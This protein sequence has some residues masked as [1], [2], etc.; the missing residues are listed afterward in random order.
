MAPA[1][2]TVADHLIAAARTY[3]AVTSRRLGSVSQLVESAAHSADAFP[4]PTMSANCSA[5]VI[6]SCPE[7]V[8]HARQR[9]IIPAEIPM[10]RCNH[11][12]MQ[13]SL[14]ISTLHSSAP[15]ASGNPRYAEEATSAL[16]TL[17]V[18]P[19]LLDPHQR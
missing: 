12:P 10:H 7:P 9:V 5:S 14:F 3:P 13:C 11:V 15:P 2:R 1:P 4:V 18:V 17:L 19:G 16:M 6:I 8:V